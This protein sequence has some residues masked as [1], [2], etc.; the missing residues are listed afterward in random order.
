MHAGDAPLRASRQAFRVGDC[1]R[2][3]EG[4]KLERAKAASADVF[5]SACRWAL[6]EVLPMINKFD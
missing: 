3:A 6:P 4:E 1:A 5:N 2:L